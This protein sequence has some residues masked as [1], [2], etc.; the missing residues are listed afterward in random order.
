MKT[1]FDE[2]MKKRL[3]ETKEYVSKLSEAVVSQVQRVYEIRLEV[4]YNEKF[5]FANAYLVVDYDADGLSVR[6]I[7]KRQS[8]ISLLTMLGELLTSDSRF[9]SDLDIYNSIVEDE[10]WKRV[11]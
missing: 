3:I 2:S 10:E 6:E 9:I 11:L 7:S 5:D 8:P 4:Y 1:Q